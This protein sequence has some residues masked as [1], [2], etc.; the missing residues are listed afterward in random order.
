M[1]KIT[2]AAARKNMRMTQAQMAEALG[3]T[4]CNYHNL[5]AGKTR[6]RKVYS[7]AFS[8]VTGFEPEEL[9]F[10]NEIEEDKT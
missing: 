9:I 10:P 1:K 5:E 4:R 3:M 2:I 8:K 6:W 7:L